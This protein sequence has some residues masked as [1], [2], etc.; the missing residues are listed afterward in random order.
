MRYHVE[1]VTEYKYAEYVG[2]SYQIAHLRPR[3]CAWQTCLAHR[4]EISPKPA[5]SHEDFDYFGNPVTRCELTE[6][7]RVLRVSATSE[8]DVHRDIGPLPSSPPWEK[9]ATQFAG[10]IWGNDEDSAACE[11]IFASEQIEYSDAVRR[12]ALASFT[13]GRPILAAAQALMESI[14][15]GF[16]YAPESTDVSTTIEEVL[17]IRQGVCQDFAHLMIGAMRS[18]GLPARYVSGYLLT[19]PPPGQ[20]RLIG[21]DASHAWVAVYVPGMGWT[22]FDPTNNLR[23]GD[24]HITLAWGRDF[25]DVSPLRGVILGGGNHK[26]KVEVTVTPE[27]EV[28][29]NTRA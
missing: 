22:E 13:S 11:F 5:V 25:A 2:V 3:D 18:L 23:P 16:E 17:E 14:Y 4:L 27:D 20:P 29:T 6:A 10:P 19:S 15:N 21:A 7:H 26:L 8:V 1:H 28:L 12:F 24:A 9:I